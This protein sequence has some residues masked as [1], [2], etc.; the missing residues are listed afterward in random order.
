M[1]KNVADSSQSDFAIL[2]EAISVFSDIV[3][4]PH[5][6]AEVSSLARQIKGPAK[7]RIQI[8]LRQLLE[9]TPEIQ[10]LLGYSVLNFL[11]LR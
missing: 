8:N 3:L 5:I 2:G 6:M 9:T 10:I 11:H 7:S 1:R 4:L